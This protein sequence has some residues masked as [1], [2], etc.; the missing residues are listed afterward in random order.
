M[1]YFLRV[2]CLL[3][4]FSFLLLSIPTTVCAS[5]FDEGL[6]SVGMAKN[7]YFENTDTKTVIAVSFNRCFLRF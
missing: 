6:P 2:F 4:L 3:L 7:V 1:R 5:S